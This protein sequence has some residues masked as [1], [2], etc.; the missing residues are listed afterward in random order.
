MLPGVQPNFDTDTL[1]VSCHYTSFHLCTA[2]LP[3]RRSGSLMLPCHCSQGSRHPAQV[4]CD[5]VRGMPTRPRTPSP[6][7]PRTPSPIRPRTPSPVRDQFAEHANYSRVLDV[8]DAALRQ[9]SDTSLPSRHSFIPPNPAPADSSELQLLRRQNE[10]LR[11]LLKD[12]CRE[13]RVRDD[14]A[15]KVQQLPTDAHTHCSHCA[16][17]C[18][19]LLNPVRKALRPLL[20]LLVL[21]AA[22][23]A[24]CR[25]TQGCSA[26]WTT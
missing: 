23:W 14:R 25:R 5:Q 1:Q 22:H 26:E 11:R 8:A 6:V 7:R 21:T 19:H 13:L 17:P 15:E 20:P 9:I 4:L 16:Q 18:S 24:V 2:R 3:P 10:Q 12:K